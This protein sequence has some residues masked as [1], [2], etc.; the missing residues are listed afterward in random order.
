MELKIKRLDEEAKLPTKGH[1]GDAGIDFFALETVTFGP[2]KQERVR[3][4][5]ALEIPDGHVGLIWDKSSL[6]FQRG[7]KVMGGVIDT[8][9][10]GEVTMSLLNTSSQEQSIEKGQKIAQMIIQK[11]E[12]VS[13]VEVSDLSDTVR[14]NGRE[15]STGGI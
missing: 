4:G 10:R 8:G 3:T 7:F 12:D 11:F 15:G 6:S 2:G 14:G 9:F 1:P 5:I 13:L